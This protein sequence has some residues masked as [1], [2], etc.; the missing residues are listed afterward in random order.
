MHHKH[1][2]QQSQRKRFYER[3]L[4]SYTNRVAKDIDVRGTEVESLLTSSDQTIRESRELDAMFEAMLMERRFYD[5]ADE[6]AY[7]DDDGNDV[8][9]E[10]KA[11]SKESTELS[12]ADWQG[13]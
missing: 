12:Y 10:R 6:E 9:V 7:N 8:Y 3:E 4:Q 1:A 13:T 11:S 5:V 2:G